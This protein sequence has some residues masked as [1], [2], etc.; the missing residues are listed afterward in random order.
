M[1]KL[2]FFVRLL[3][4]NLLTFAS[5]IILS[6]RA[7]AGCSLREGRITI[8]LPIF[9]VNFALNSL[10]LLLQRPIRRGQIL[11]LKYS[12]GG[13]EIYPDVW[14]CCAIGDNFQT[15]LIWA[16]IENLFEIFENKSVHSK[17]R[18]VTSKNISNIY[19]KRYFIP[20]HKTEKLFGRHIRE[21][22]EVSW[23]AGHKGVARGR[24]ETPPPN[25]K[26]L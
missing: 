15:G 21:E 23:T 2:S 4:V 12:A 13:S 17:W 19:F 1:Y 24:G 8:H 5:K 18:F 22:C 14:I 11:S 6:I 7:P 3:E 10:F 26:M 20:F 25:R 16:K 9:P